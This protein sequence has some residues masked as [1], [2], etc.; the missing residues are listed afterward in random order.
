MRRSP[1]RPPHRT[2]TAKSQIT[3]GGFQNYHYDS[4][5]ADVDYKGTRLGLDAT[6]Q[7]SPTEYITAKGSVPTSLFQ[8]SPT[9][10]HVEPAPGEAIDLQVK[11]SAISLGLIQGFTNQVTN[12]QGT[13]QADVHVTGSGQDPHAAGLCRHQGRSVRCSGGGRDIHRPD[14]PDRAAAGSDQGARRSSCS[15]AMA[16]SFVLPANWRS[17]RVNSAP[18]TSTSTPTTSKSSTTSWATCSCRPR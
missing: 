18:S 1:D 3:N 7:Q 10:E 15:I 12:V 9:G 4:L 16:R 2:S 6:L 11:S 13:L 17:T 14:D 8:A 5:A